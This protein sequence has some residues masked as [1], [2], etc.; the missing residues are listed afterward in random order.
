M[1]KD[2]TRKRFLINLVSV[3]YGTQADR[4]ADLIRL[5]FVQKQY[6]CTVTIY[7]I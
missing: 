2:Q 4:K 6:N 7:D 5:I 1:L 3:K